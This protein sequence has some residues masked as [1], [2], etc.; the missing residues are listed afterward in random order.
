MPTTYEF[1]GLKELNNLVNGIP[2]EFNR[3]FSTTAKKY[4]SSMVSKSQS[5]SPVRT[6]RLRNSIGSKA[7]QTQLQFFA[8][9]PYAKFVDQGTYRMPGRPF[10]TG[11]HQEQVPKMIDE[12]NKGLAN[13]IK[14]NARK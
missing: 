8:D 3:I 7:D 9:A 2:A 5:K 12:L 14:A 11:T 1:V 10:F 13:Y 6:G 4:A